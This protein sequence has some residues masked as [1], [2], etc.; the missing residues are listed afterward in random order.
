MKFK[1]NETIEL[2][3]STS[4]L[5]EAIISISSILN[6][7]GKGVVYFGIEDDGKVV[8]QQMGKSTI[9]DIS[10]SIADHIDPK[11]FPDIKILKISGQDCIAAEFSGH[12]GLYSAYGRFYLRTGGEDK[13]LST[14]EIE[15]L[16]EKKKNYVYSW[17]VEVSETP[18]AEA[19]VSTLRI[20]IKK[21]K[22]Q[23]ESVFRLTLQ[24][25]FSISFT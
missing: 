19:N 11:I 12:E 16:I 10:K 7:H 25:T 14:K 5:K 3:K 15:R 21:A 8:G 20:F 17:G 2:K 13:K 9:K 18:I 1:E 22:K 6:K 23:E 24:R 4:E